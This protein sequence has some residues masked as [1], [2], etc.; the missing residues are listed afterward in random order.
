ML[1]KDLTMEEICAMDLSDLDN[2]YING[3]K[4]VLTDRQKEELR[5]LQAELRR[6]KEQDFLDEIDDPTKRKD[7]A[8]KLL[9]EFSTLFDSLSI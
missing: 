4:V 5:K 1:G 2:L 3:K 9:E 8:N 7:L 6:C